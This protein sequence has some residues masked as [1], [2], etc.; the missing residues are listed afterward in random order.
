MSDSDVTRIEPCGGTVLRITHRSG[1]VHDTDFGY[2]LR[3]NP[4]DSVFASF[5]AETIQ[6]AELV[7]GTVAWHRPE[8]VVDLAAHV[9]EEHAEVG[10]CVGSCGWQPGDSVVIR[11]ATESEEEL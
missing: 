1:L 11:C 7:N 5:T 10:E 4:P 2:V 9:L 6:A 8:G 3:D